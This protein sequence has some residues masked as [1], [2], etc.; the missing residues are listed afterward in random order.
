MHISFRTAASLLTLSAVLALSGCAV[1]YDKRGKPVYSTDLPELFGTVMDSQPLPGSQDPITLRRMGDQWSLKFGSFSRVVDLGTLQS[2]RIVNVSQVGNATNILLQIGTPQCGRQYQLVSVAARTRAKVWPL[3]MPCS[4]VV[5][6]VQTGQLEQYIDF[7]VG[8][9]VS[10]FVYRDGKFRRNDDVVLPPGMTSLPGPAGGGGP[11]GAPAGDRYRPGPPFAPNA[12][13]LRE[14]PEAGASY[15]P[16]ATTP[17]SATTTPPAAQQAAPRTRRTSSG[18]NAGAS[19]GTAR[20]PGHIDFGRE[21]KPT[22]T[23]DLTK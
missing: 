21:I 2:G 15:A 6:Q 16:A 10:R 13:Q 8:S 18:S 5:P 22:I 11:A 3:D 4:D 17:A 14:R 1:Q 7:V 9:R 20:T 19:A 12:N 23:V